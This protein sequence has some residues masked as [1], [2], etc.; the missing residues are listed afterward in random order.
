MLALT[1][2]ALACFMIGATRV[3]RGRRRQWLKGT[4]DRIHPPR[5]RIPRVGAHARAANAAAMAA[6]FQLE[7]SKES[8]FS[9]RHSTRKLPK[10]Q[11]CKRSNKLYTAV[12][13][14]SVRKLFG[15]Q[16]RPM[17]ICYSSRPIGLGK[18][19]H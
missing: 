3:R 17:S 5:A 18:L 11:F 14:R 2:S 16:D 10:F 19:P 13:P 15:T 7:P 1:D 9:L 12:R 4:A 8:N 6:V